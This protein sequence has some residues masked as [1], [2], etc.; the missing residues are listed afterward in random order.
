M[1]KNI[2]NPTEKYRG[3]IL[4]I[5]N[6]CVEFPDGTKKSFEY[7]ERAPGVRVIVTDGSNIL[8]TKELW[9]ATIILQNRTIRGF[10]H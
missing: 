10:F 6:Q 5:M 9:D 4:R 2:G 1:I 7:A 3:R 8:L